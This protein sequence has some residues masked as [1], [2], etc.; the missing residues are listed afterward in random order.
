[1]IIPGILDSDS[2]EEDVEPNACMISIRKRMIMMWWSRRT[3]IIRTVNHHWESKSSFIVFQTAT[4]VCVQ[5]GKY[6]IGSSG[7]FV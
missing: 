7:Q 1:M 3:I 2:R 5:L 6:V 4:F